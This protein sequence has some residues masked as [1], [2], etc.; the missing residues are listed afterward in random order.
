MPP[1]LQSVPV[2]FVI[3]G[4]GAVGLEVARQLIVEKRDVVMIERDVERARYASNNLDCMVINDES[5]NLET[6]RRAGVKRADYFISLT[7]SDEMNM[8]LSGLVA[9][10]FNVPY[11][12]ARIRN[13]EY[14]AAGVLDSSFLGID[15]IV[16]PAVE[17]GRSIVRAIEHGAVS[18][19]MFFQRSTVQMRNLPVG[20]NSLFVGHSLAEIRQRLG[21]T[22][23]VSVIVRGNATLIPSGNTKI[24]AFDNLYI[25]ASEKEFDQLL[26]AMGKFKVRLSKIIIVGG[27]SVGQY[28][29]ESLLRD[30][31]GLGGRVQNLLGS[32][33]RRGKRNISLIEQ[34]QRRCKELSQ[35]FPEALVIH[36]D[37]AAEG[38]FE[39]EGLTD[40]DAIVCTTGNQELNIVTSIYAKTLGIKRAVALVTKN[41]YVHIASNLGIDAPVSMQN[42]MVGSILKFIR[43]G[44]I[45]SVYNISGGDL[46]VVEMP[47]QSGSRLAARM[48][49][50]I[51]FPAE[52]LILALT[53]DAQT[54]IPE[55]TNHLEAGDN[56]IFI[57]RKES[58]PRIE[59][60]F[61]AQA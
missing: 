18:D 1:I 24:E 59:R 40:A 17:A 2:T 26:L 45:D 58:A 46:E 51:K 4:A 27:G 23:L 34:D 14:S 31:R 53:R 15:C 6:L 21:L 5:T 11:R 41:S 32:L 16:N 20:E 30:H 33:L 37:I 54:I 8:I 61:G 44:N 29:L 19:I 49:R 38:I 50:E 47:V 3:V 42:S 10:E 52:T 36:G 13:I 60:M 12:I 25:L 56:V 48:I 28:V 22:F 43:H 55:G 39:E 57:A 7:D 35:R 9:R